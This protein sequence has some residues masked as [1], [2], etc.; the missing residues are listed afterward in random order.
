MLFT[1]SSLFLHYDEDKD[2][3]L[4]LLSCCNL[5]ILSNFSGSS[6]DIKHS[7]KSFILV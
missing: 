2:S 4:M 1:N 7:Y 6:V 3:C 5:A